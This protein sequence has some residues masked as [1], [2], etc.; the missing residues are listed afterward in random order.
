[1]FPQVD[2][3]LWAASELL[4]VPG[5]HK[6]RPEVAVHSEIQQDCDI[7]L[8]CHN[9]SDKRVNHELFRQYACHSG[10]GWSE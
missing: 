8:P 1:M 7:G 10:G 3:D 9:H 5:K 4:K 6:P 2:A